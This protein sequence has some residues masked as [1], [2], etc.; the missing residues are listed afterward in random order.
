MIE[1][2]RDKL[3]PCVGVM[4]WKEGKILL[5]KRKGSHG[6]GEYAFPGGHLEFDE[7]FRE[8]TKREIL[9][10][11]NIEI[12]NLEFMSLA[13]F[14]LNENRQDILVSFSAEWESGDLKIM[15][16]EKCDGWGWYDLE[17]LPSPLFYPTKITIDSYKTGKKFYDKE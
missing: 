15:E 17:D 10:E 2:Q 14:I 7:S 9:E 1:G 13:N 3:K 4:I 11:I 16:P 6:S 5:G 8:C 12:K